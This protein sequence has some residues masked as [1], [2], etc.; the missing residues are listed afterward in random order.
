MKIYK[1][2]ACLLHD[3]LSGAGLQ[4]YNIVTLNFFSF[5]IVNYDSVYLI[6]IFA[7]NKNYCKNYD[8]IKIESNPFI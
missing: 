6:I 4:I 8:L 2:A 5:K 3:V 1:E 7:K